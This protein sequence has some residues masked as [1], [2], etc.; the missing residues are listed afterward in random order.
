MITTT[1]YFMADS[2][3][4]TQYLPLNCLIYYEFYRTDSE[5]IFKSI[6][7]S[8]HLLSCGS[9][10][11]FFFVVVAVRIMCVFIKTT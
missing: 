7:L 3:M 6:L 2:V 10:E 11:T 9:N 1:F 8:I 5:N 4:I